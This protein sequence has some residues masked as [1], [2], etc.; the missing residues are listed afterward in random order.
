MVVIGVVVR[1]VVVTLVRMVVCLVSVA[2]VVVRVLIVR[3]VTVAAAAERE[4]N[5]QCQNGCK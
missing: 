3:G 1:R 4:R 2:C 5:G